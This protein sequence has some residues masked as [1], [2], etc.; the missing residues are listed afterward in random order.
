METNIMKYKDWIEGSNEGIG[1]GIDNGSKQN[2]VQG[3]DRGK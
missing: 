2:E 1:N 3:S